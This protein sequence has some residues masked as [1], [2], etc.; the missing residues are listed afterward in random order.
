MAF[1]PRSVR[2]SSALS[3]LNNDL[4]GLAKHEMFAHSMNEDCPSLKWTFKDEPT[5][6]GEHYTSAHISGQ[7]RQYFD[8]F[9]AGVITLEVRLNS[10]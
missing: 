1:V 10:S 9:T 8:M 7:G 5:P 3:L 6:G 2:C 4:K